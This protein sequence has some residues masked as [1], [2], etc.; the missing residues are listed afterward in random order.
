M[1][2]HLIRR[3]IFIRLES[4]TSA[5]SHCCKELK[6]E[7]LTADLLKEMECHLMKTRKIPDIEEY[8]EVSKAWRFGVFVYVI[9]CS[10]IKYY[11]ISVQ[12]LNR[13]NR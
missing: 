9:M 12:L 8:G 4:G 5:N 10:D 7:L 13:H 3:L 1:V 11:N 2:F 6:D